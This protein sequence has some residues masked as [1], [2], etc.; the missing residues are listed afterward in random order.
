[1]TV[2]DGV[3]ARM[4]PVLSADAAACYWKTLIPAWVPGS[5]R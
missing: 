1:M 4:D 5:S 3:D 2:G